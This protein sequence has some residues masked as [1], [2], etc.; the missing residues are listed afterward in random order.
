M[1]RT[2]NKQ[3]SIFNSRSHYY[4]LL[5]FFQFSIFIKNN[6]K[7]VQ[8]NNEYFHSNMKYFD[9]F[10]RVSTFKI[11]IYIYIHLLDIHKYFKTCFY[12]QRKKIKEHKRN[13]AYHRELKQW[14][15][16]DWWTK[17]ITRDWSARPNEYLFY[18]FNFFSL[19]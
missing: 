13:D 1:K 8:I 14:N 17:N 2:S 5:E 12:I 9:I 18:V 7:W 19:Y 6:I 16:R 10:N 4:S 3:L 15:A 11:Y